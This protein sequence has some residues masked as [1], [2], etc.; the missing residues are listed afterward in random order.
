M[1]RKS[2]I[3]LGNVVMVPYRYDT[4]FLTFRLDKPDYTNQV[5]S[6]QMQ[7][8]D[9]TPKGEMLHIHVA[10]LYRAISANPHA[11]EARVCAVQAKQARF[12]MQNNGIERDYLPKI[13]AKYL[14]QPGIMVDWGNTFQTIIDGNH[15]YVKRWMKHKPDMKFWVVTPEQ[16][17]PALLD[18]PD[19]L[20]PV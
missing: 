13:D 19:E 11:Y 15:R 17:R 4:G 8:D 10:K 2:L 1:N 3:V 9:G 6:Y 18:M 12:I 7:H 16:L 14:E 20:A 5:F